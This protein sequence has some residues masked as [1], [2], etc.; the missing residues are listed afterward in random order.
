MTI[1]DQARDTS[2]VARDTPSLRSAALL[3]NDTFCECFIKCETSGTVFEIAT[4]P[5]RGQSNDP[6]F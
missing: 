5:L 1:V 3:T 6:P 4:F 2:E